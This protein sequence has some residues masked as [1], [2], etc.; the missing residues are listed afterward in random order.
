MR[1]SPLQIAE[2]FSRTPGPRYRR[3]G[4]FSGE[5]FRESV[6]LPRVKEAL[7]NGNGFLVDLDGTDGY[8]TSFLEEAFG[9]LVREDGIDASDLRK[10]LT[11][12]SDEE[13]YLIADAWSYI[14][15]AK[16]RG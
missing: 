8:G 11:F 7:A 9:G 1:E 14:D 15:A 6:L 2:V 3:E 4:E 12:K 10:T 5:E 13:E 16:A